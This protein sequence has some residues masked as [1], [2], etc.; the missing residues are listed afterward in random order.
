MID[1]KRGRHVFYQQIGFQYFYV[2]CQLIYYNSTKNFKISLF[3]VCQLS[4]N[5]HDAKNMVNEEG[6]HLILCVCEDILSM[7]RSS[8]QKCSVKK[9]V[10]KNLTI[11]AAWSIETNV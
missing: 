6:V 7:F 1:R 10:L 4:E 3:F 9:D 2:F 11:F 5:I 8:H